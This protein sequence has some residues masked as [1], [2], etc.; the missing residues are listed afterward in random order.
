MPIQITAI[1]DL[2]DVVIRNQVERL[3]EISPEFGSGQDA[4]T[5]LENALEQDTIL[6]VAMFNDKI[7]GAIWSEGTGTTRLLEYVIIHP[8]NRNRGVADRLI[9]EVCRIEEE[10]GVTTFQPGCGAIHRCLVHLGKL[11]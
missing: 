3:Y 11:Q 10:K 7:I 6:Y 4:I 2:K 9:S 5:T 8:A 1:T